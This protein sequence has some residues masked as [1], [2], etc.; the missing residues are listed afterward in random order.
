MDPI[1]DYV[2]GLTKFGNVSDYLVIN[3]SSPNTPGL[4][5]MQTK[6]ALQAL[7][8]ELVKAKNNLLSETKPRI[9]LKLAPDLKYEELCDIADVLKLKSCTIDGLII[10]NTTVDRPTSLLNESNKNEIGGLSG[11]P[12]KD[13]STEMIAKM[14]KLTDGMTIIGEYVSPLLPR[15]YLIFFTC[16]CWWSIHWSGCI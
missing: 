3:I 13:R 11:Q 15:F 10:S 7:L 12:L 14:Y 5:N 2:Q 1:Q 9:L 16:R 6:V 4:R 8:S